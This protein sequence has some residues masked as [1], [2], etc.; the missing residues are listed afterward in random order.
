MQLAWRWTI[1]GENWRDEPPVLPGATPGSL[2][3]C[4][5][6][7]TRTN[8]NAIGPCGIAE[9]ILDYWDRNVTGCSFDLTAA[10]CPCGVAASARRSVRRRPAV[11]R[12]QMDL[13]DPRGSART[14]SVT[15]RTRKH[16]C[17]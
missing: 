12:S 9:S 8:P 6:L 13:P 3:P 1:P 5:A 17:P 4:R 14:A 15:S 7:G 10:S 2:V 11:I 16:D